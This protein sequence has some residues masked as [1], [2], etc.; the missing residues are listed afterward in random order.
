MEM[1]NQIQTPFYIYG[2]GIVASSIYTA[3]KYLYNVFPESFLV[4]TMEE[5]NPE[6]IDG[7]PVKLFKEL[8]HKEREFLYVV[9]APEV[10]HP[11]IVKMLKDH[12][13]IDRQIFLI[14]NIKENAIMEEYYSRRNDFLTVRDILSSDRNNHANNVD[15]Q[16]Y[17]ARCHV[18]KALRVLQDFPEYIYPVQVGT[19][20][21]DQRIAVLS[22]SS[23]DNISEKNRNYCE[24]TATYWAWK[25]RNIPYKGLCHYRRIFDLSSKQLQNIFTENH[26]VDAI[27][28]YPTFYYPGMETE[29][30]RY[31][32]QDDWKAMLQALEAVAPDYYEA[33]KTI[34]GEPYFYNYNMLIAK[35]EVFNDYSN[36]LF[37]VLKETEKWLLVKETERADRFAGYLAENLTT[38]YFRANKGRYKIAHT[39]KVLLT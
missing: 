1:T 5:N 14:D 4:S 34:A 3:W 22:D 37:S 11:A 24:L 18:D 16:V 32:K 10:H 15:I 19:V 26:K 7:I 29:H 31:I 8:N 21:T 23:G 17:Q 36:F 20:L 12:G 13:I 2:A 38:I 30:L 33:Y 28:P 25:N 39:G 6:E 9:A 35:Q 27:L